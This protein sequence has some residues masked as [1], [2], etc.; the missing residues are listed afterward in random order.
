MAFSAVASSA[1]NGNSKTANQASVAIP[2]LNTWTAGRLLLIFVACDN[3]QTTD[4]DENAITSMTDDSGGTNVYQ[5][6]AA[7][8]AGRGA[9]QGG[10]TIEL[11]YSLL[12]SNLT[13]SHTITA[14]LSNAT[15]RDATARSTQAFDIGGGNTI[16]I[17]GTPATNATTGGD[18]P[19]MNVTTANIECLRVRA[20]AAEID[21][22]TFTATASPVFVA[23]SGSNTT[24]GSAVTNMAVKGEYIISTGT[25]AASDPT[26]FTADHASVYVA[27]KEV[28]AVRV[29]KVLPMTFQ[30]WLAQ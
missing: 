11:W 9:A 7:Y 20:I 25:G 3:N 14:N 12:T 17:E 19:S 4:G 26:G 22:G 28:S 8:T 29:P 18:P 16:S 21:T 1:S 15:S 23:I 24:G 10:A 30:P 13:T 27:F 5:K 2:G 6:A